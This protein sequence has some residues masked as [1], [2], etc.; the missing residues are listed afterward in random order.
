MPK[1]SQT[2]WIPSRTSSNRT[3]YQDLLGACVGGV[4]LASEVMLLLPVVVLQVV[5]QHD[6]AGL[7]HGHHLAEHLKLHRGRQ[8]ESQEV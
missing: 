4:D 8:A 6:I 2:A 1:N 5:H 7:L 3:W